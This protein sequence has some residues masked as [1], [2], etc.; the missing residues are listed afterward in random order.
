[1]APAVATPVDA[2]LTASTGAQGI[3]VRPARATKGVPAPFVQQQQLQR[4][5]A[6]AAAAAAVAAAPA[7]LQQQLQQQYF[8]PSHTLDPEGPRAAARQ[9]AAAAFGSSSPVAGAG[10]ARKFNNQYRGVRQRPWG[11]WAAE[12]RDPTKG[13]RLWLGTFDTAEEAA[14][15][16]DSAA[17]EIRG[18]NAVRL[19]IRARARVAGGLGGGQA[20]AGPARRVGS[21][22]A[23]V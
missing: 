20:G 14:R 17:R 7:A 11:K 6:A 22:V 5:A 3:E 9:A 10:A 21:A 15:A 1:M 19:Q 2:P 16:Y 13:Q 8:L 18:P 12:I 23:A 4:A